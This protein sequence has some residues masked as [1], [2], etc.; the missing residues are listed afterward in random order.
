MDF[1]D[2]AEQGVLD[3]LLLT[4]RA[5]MDR[6]L[7]AL[8][9]CQERINVHL[10]RFTTH[11][12]SSSVAFHSNFSLSHRHLAAARMPCFLR[13]LYHMRI[14]PHAGGHKASQGENM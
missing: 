2:V 7:L 3:H 8:D 4:E 12:L 5:S 9:E 10:E 14:F 11:T 1:K 6:L 13:A